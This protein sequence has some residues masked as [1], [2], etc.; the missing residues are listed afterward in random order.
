MND[1]VRPD[2][3]N[4]SIG[5]LREYASHMHIPL[6][7]TAKKEEIKAAI[8]QKLAGRAGT[9]LAAQVSS[10]P[11]GHAKI[12]I[13]EDPSPG[14][15]QVPVFLNCN[16]YMCTIPRGKEVI[17]PMRV[18]RTLQDAKVKKLVQQ[19]ATDNWGRPISQ[20]TTVVVPSYPFQLLE[21]TPG[22][23][24]LT[25]HEKLK[26]KSNGPRQRY[27]ELFGHWPRPADLRRAIEKGLI[28]LHEDEIVN[29]APEQMLEEPTEE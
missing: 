26:Q 6:A 13:H 1:I 10:V 2:F 8:V 24:P 15:Q 16:G 22:P 17:V 20:T 23:E 7:K 29:L 9:V 18:V 28:K 19:D 3:D 25:A 11:P 12:M 21:V 27:A 14:S 5:H 4:M